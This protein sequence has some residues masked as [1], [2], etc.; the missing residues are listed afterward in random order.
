[1]S[2]A[3]PIRELTEADLLE[4]IRDVSQAVIAR[5]MPQVVAEGLIAPTFWHL[6]YLERS[7]VKHPSELARRLGIT[8]ATCTW[9][10][11]QLVALGLVARRPSENDRR[12]I[13]LAVTPKGRRTLESVWRRFDASLDEALASLSPKDVTVTS[14][15]LRV[16][17]E[18]LRKEPTAIGREE[19]S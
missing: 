13:V 16:I 9:S 11:D 19:R 7:G 4:A 3:L 10:V 6:H 12:H 5:L 8:P 15:T 1:M 18:H 2:A 14:R 17:A